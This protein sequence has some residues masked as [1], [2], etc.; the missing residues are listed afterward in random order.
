MEGETGKEGEMGM[1]VG[2]R[3]FPLAEDVA[4]S[5]LGSILP[6]HILPTVRNATN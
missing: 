1:E 6:S 4:F 5:F 2:M 3:C